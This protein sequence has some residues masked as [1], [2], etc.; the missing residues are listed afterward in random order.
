MHSLGNVHSRTVA[1]A[2][3]SSVIGSLF[4]VISGGTQFFLVIDNDYFNFTL[5]L[6]NL[7]SFN[8]FNSLSLSAISSLSLEFYKY[9]TDKNSRQ[10]VYKINNLD[11]N[12]VQSYEFFCR[13]PRPVFRCTIIDN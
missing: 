2:L 10:K 4:T 11:Q 12:L 6:L 9:P 13:R 7:I 1:A 8:S 3:W 5:F